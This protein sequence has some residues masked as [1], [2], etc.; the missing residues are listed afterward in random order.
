MN[1]VS[2]NKSLLDQAITNM[3]SAI[4]KKDVIDFTANI[5][6][7]TTY[8]DATKKDELILKATEHEIYI[9]TKIEINLIQGE[10]KCAVNAEAIGNFIKGLNDGE[11]IIQECDNKLYIKQD[12]DSEFE[13]STFE[14]NDFLFKQNYKDEEQEF[15]PID[16]DNNLFLNSL[17][18][19][20][21]CCNNKDTI[22]N[23]AMQG[24]LFEIKDKKISIVATDSRRLG[25]IQ[26]KTEY[27][28][29][30]TGI[31]PKK[32]IQEILKLF[33]T[34]FEIYIKKMNDGNKIET[35]C[36]VNQYTQFYTKLINA[37]FPDF[38]SIISNK[39]KIPTLKINK[40]K[41]LKTLNQL[42]AICQRAKVTF[43]SNQIIFET[44]E[45]ING[46]SALIKI[47]NIENNQEKTITIG[48]VNKHLLDC[49][50]N[51]KQEEFEMIIEDP[52]KPIFITTKEFEEIIMPQVI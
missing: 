34:D 49:I 42:N 52:Y 19:I 38:R 16:I 23:N 26:K 37:N 10:I 13:I 29:E 33:S 27:N 1:I 15:Q 25:Y 41:F 47:N 8:N 5:S 43:Q 45:G 2:I 46:A 18:T 12:N 28:N 40:E 31:I 51:I 48:L 3:Q 9:Q 11:V 50:N 17:K 30:F 24:V 44:L 39:P 7:E 35:I 6:L 4:N 36:F 32:T 14:I 22:I 21:H 20:M